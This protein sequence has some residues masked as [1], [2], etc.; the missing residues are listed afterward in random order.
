MLSAAIPVPDL[1]AD[2]CLYGESDRVPLSSRPLPVTPGIRKGLR[3]LARRLE[4]AGAEAWAAAG[5]VAKRDQ[6]LVE[7]AAEWLRGFP[8]GHFSGRRRDGLAVILAALNAELVD[9]RTLERTKPEWL[10]RRYL[11]DHVAAVDYLFRRALR[12]D[13]AFERRHEMT[14]HLWCLKQQDW[15]APR[16]GQR[17][18]RTTLE[19]SRRGI[20]DGLVGQPDIGGT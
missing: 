16:N 20:P 15:G 19:T 9:S 12:Y 3:R 11:R 4:C 2:P 17:T 18:T 6:A 10:E 7:E 8:L 14:P 5:S 1:L 13:D